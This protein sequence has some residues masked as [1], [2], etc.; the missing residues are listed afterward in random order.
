MSVC[1][2]LEYEAEKLRPPSAVWTDWSTQ[3][4]RDSVETHTPACGHPTVKGYSVS[5]KPHTLSQQHLPAEITPLQQLSGH[6]A[7]QF[8]EKSVFPVLLPGVDA[9]QKEAVK[10]G[11]FERKIT[12]FNPCDFLTEWLYNHN[13]CRRGQRPVNFSDIPFV[14]EWLSMHPRPPVPLFLRLSQA[15]AAVIIQAFW[16][17]YKVR[18]R[19]DVQELCQWQR[20]LRENQDITKTVENFWAHQESRVG[21]SMTD[22]PESPQL[23]NSDVSIQVVSPTPQSTVVHTPTIQMT[24]GLGGFP[25]KPGSEATVRR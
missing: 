9:L 20:E 13:P 23:D 1:E 12:A 3:V 6:P 16:R 10:Q 4:S 21:S 19:P 2:V 14:K 17:G 25:S 7:T 11:C 18:A 24:P 8:L 22:L 5:G 15:R